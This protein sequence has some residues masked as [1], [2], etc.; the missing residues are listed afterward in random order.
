MCSENSVLILQSFEHRMKIY[1]Q[2]G[3]Y[4]DKERK[5]IKENTKKERM[6]KRIRGRKEI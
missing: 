1:L 5:M 2:R 6:A 4:L 3:E